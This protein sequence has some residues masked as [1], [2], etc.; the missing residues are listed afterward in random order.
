MIEDIGIEYWHTS[1]YHYDGVSEW[2]R[3][4]R[5]FGRWCG[6]ELFGNEVEPPFCQGELHPQ[7]TFANDYP[8]GEPF[9]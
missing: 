4:D 7:H 5:R 1:L 2:L 3:N 9:Q 8:K 6:K